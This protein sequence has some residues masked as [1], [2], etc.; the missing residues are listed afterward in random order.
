M[1]FLKKNGIQSSIH[2]PPIHLF[3][4][5]RK[6]FGFNKGLLPLTEFIG[7]REVTLP[8]HPLLKE[9]DIKYIAEKI[10][11]FCETVK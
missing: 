5:Y 3:S 1:E 2:Y 9:E 4:Y 11:E 7:E 10:I 8:L 6:R